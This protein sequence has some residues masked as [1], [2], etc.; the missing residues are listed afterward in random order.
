M[1]RHT[2]NI[3]SQVLVHCLGPTTHQLHTFGIY[4]TSHVR[5]GS[6]ATRVVL[7]YSRRG[8]SR[9]K[10]TPFTR[11]TEVMLEGLLLC[12]AV[13]RTDGHSPFHSTIRLSLR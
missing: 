7:Y 6:G 4:S 1:I 10:W 9:S 8:G 2:E 13:V 3:V 12:S 11:V 5:W